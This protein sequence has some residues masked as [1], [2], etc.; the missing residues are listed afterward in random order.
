MDDQRK[1]KAQL[2]DEVKALRARAAEL[3]DAL[4]ERTR[5]EKRTLHDATHDVLTG[6]Y[7]R[8]HLLE[9]LALAVQSAKR[10]DYPLSLCRCSL[11][12][13]ESVYEAQGDAAADEALVT[14]GGL[15]M[16]EL[17][18]CDVVGR[19]GEEFCI[20]FPQTPAANAAMAA[21]RICRR[22]EE[23]V[24]PLPVTAMFGIAGLAPEDM[25]E[26]DLL[27]SAGEALREAKEGGG[28]RIVVYVP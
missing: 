11:Y 27:A 18:Q 6:V 3:E 8:T 2:L 24:R 7:N 23:M 4:G 22:F 17:R 13:I 10:Y 19:Y 26:A 9:R 25:E 5:A 14:F 28:D 12:G 15:V 20:V 1:S 21:E 16:A